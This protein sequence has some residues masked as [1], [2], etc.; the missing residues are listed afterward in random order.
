VETTTTSQCL[1]CGAGP[2]ATYCAECGQKAG[3][4]NPTLHE[5]L[6]DVWHEVLHIGG[7]VLATAR[8]LLSRPG[9]LTRE[10]FAISLGWLMLR[11]PGGLV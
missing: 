5:V 1:N 6:H 2:V 4:L 9:F 7:K 11:S 8:V 10:Y 3:H